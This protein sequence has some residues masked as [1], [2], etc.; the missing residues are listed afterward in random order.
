M[1][2]H[3]FSASQKRAQWLQRANPYKQKYLADAFRSG[4]RAYWAGQG[5]ELHNFN[6]PEKAAFWAGYDAAAEQEATDD[7]ASADPGY[8]VPAGQTDPA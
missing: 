6:R 5:V 2:P 1:Q 4:A 7:E 8:Y 3:V